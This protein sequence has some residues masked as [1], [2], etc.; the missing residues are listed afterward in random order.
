MVMDGR[1]GVW[2]SFGISVIVGIRGGESAGRSGGLLIGGFA[3]DI[4]DRRLGYVRAVVRLP[5]W[6]GTEA[7]EGTMGVNGQESLYRINS[8]HFMVSCLCVMRSRGSVGDYY[9]APKQ[10]P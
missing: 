7:Q 5:R 4:L 9:M 1:S 10:G 8:V 3:N 2:G 6:S